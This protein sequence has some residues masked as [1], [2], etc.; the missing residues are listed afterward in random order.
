MMRTFKLVPAFLQPQFSLRIDLSPSGAYFA[1][2]LSVEL[3]KIL[4]ERSVG[5]MKGRLVDFTHCPFG[6]IDVLLNSASSGVQ[7]SAALCRGSRGWLDHTIISY[8][9]FC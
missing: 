7:R 2:T 1:M 3:H 4:A 6:P 5:V 8:A 9:V